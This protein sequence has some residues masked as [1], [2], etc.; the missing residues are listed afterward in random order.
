MNNYT[1]EFPRPGLTSDILLFRY[2]SGNIEILLI[3]RAEYPFAGSW[4]LPGG[5]VDEGETA[6]IAA[7]RELKEETDIAGISLKQVYT[8]TTPNR[9]PRGWTISI[10][11]YGFA[12]KTIK[13]NAGDDA[14]HSKWFPINQLPDL[15]FD[16]NEV[17]RQGLK[18]LSEQVRFKILGHEI[19]LEK[20][21]QKDLEAFYLQLLNNSTEVNR[22]I[23]RLIKNNV[24]EFKNEF[25]VFNIKRTN[26]ILEFGFLDNYF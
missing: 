14:K 5:F 3:E 7:E 19:F 21:L 22:V 17:V 23:K 26:E 2:V 24:L 16:H 10:V 13:A 11:F 15:A 18:K 20:T 1:Y 25:F 12:D 6:E 8:T 4:A 9:D